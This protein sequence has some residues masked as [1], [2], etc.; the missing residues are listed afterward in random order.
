MQN[1]TECYRMLQNV[2]ECYRMSHNVMLQNA[3]EC[4]VVGLVATALWVLANA[5]AV[6]TGATV[7][8]WPRPKDII[9]GALDPLLQGG[10]VHNNLLNGLDQ[11]IAA[12]P[13]ATGGV[14]I[15][16]FTSDVIYPGPAKLQRAND[17]EGHLTRCEVLVFA[18]PLRHQLWPLDAGLVRPALLPLVHL[19]PQR[20][21]AP[22]RRVAHLIL[23]S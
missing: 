19:L 7:V 22:H 17:I 2:T 1:V 4:H 10:H 5:Q 12:A 13:P 14:V 18:F 21:P 8:V 20:R 16:N 9:A 3:T 23:S 11:L 6:N 15:L